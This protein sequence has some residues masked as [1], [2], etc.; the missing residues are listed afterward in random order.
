MKCKK[1]GIEFNGKMCPNCG[2]KKRKIIFLRWWFL[3]L[4]F[5]VGFVIMINMRRER[6]KHYWDEQYEE[7]VWSD[8]IL[9][10]T[11]PKPPVAKGEVYDNSDEKLWVT[12]EDLS[13]EQ[14]KSYI[15]AC[16]EDGFTIEAV[17]QSNTYNAYNDK[18]YKLSLIYYS[19]KSNMKIH[20]EKPMEMT[21]ISW[22]VG[23]AGYQLPKPNSKVGK[24]SYEYDDYFFVYIGNTSKSEYSEYVNKCIEKGF[25]INYYKGEN[26]FYADNSK[27]WHVSIDYEGNDVMSIN[28]KERK[29]EETT[30]PPTKESVEVSTKDAPSELPTTEFPTTEVTTTEYPTNEEVDNGGINPDFKAAMDSYE[31]FI[32]EYVS[33]MKKYNDNPNDLELLY[34]Y[35]NYLSKYADFVADFDKW[36]DEEL[37]AEETAYYLDVQVRVSK[38]ILEI[39][40]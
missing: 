12:I 33:F 8:M 16:E 1:C 40:Y 6:R 9:G 10:G 18:G 36:K 35:S 5:I 3:L 30:Q 31:K 26:S 25:N 28:I 17:S 7:L 22:P 39:G 4:V 14:Y 15:E 2:T 38:K 13:A 20:L 21:T 27:G 19:G 24:F 34:D 37:N 32:D 29:K 11:L 23:S